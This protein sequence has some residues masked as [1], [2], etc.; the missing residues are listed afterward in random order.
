MDFILP[1]CPKHWLVKSSFI[2]HRARRNFKFLS[3]QKCIQ[4]VSKSALRPNWP[5]LPEL[6]LVSLAWSR[7]RVLLLPLDGMLVHRKLP[8]AF[9][10]RYPFILLG[11][12]RHCE[13]KVS[14]PRT[15]YGD[16]ARPELKPGP[17]DPESN[18]LTIRPPRLLL[19][20]HRARRNQ[21][22]T[23]NVKL[24]HTP[25]MHLESSK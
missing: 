3:L 25:K 24:P 5:T 21:F 16:P 9:C 10:R 19:I 18:A 7:L 13:I 4:R 6:I 22:L 12:E 17:L 2:P 11:G 8:P 20:P 23:Q 15:Q 14:C 1:E